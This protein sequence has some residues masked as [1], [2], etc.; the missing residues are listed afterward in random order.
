MAVSNEQYEA[1]LVR[2]NKLEN[3]FND[4][5]I[6]IQRLATKDLVSQL[7]AVIQQDLASLS[8]D[9]DALELRI[10]AIE[11]EPLT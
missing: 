3:A 8:A 6:A 11:E 1:M 2:L 10:T 5:A 9:V 7:L 4:L